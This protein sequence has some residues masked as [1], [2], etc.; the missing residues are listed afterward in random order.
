MV[1]AL[2]LSASYLAANTNKT[3]LSGRPLGQNL[4]METVGFNELLASNT[5]D[6][7]GAD[8]QTTYFYS[9]STNPEALG[10]YFGFND[11]NEFTAYTSTSADIN[12]GGIIYDHGSSRSTTEFIKLEPTQTVYGTRL[13]YQQN[14][15]SIFE[16]LWFRVKLPIVKVSNDMHMST[17]GA[18][19]AI[20]TDISNY[21]KGE[22]QA[23]NANDTS[24]EARTPLANALINGKRTA[25]NFAD[26][27]ANLGYTAIDNDRYTVDVNIGL[28]LPTGTKTTGMY[29]WEP[30]TGNN[31]HYELGAGVSSV[32]KLWS[33]DKGTVNFNTALDYRYGFKAT[34]KRTF[35]LNGANW[36]QYQLA[37]NVAV[38]ANN[39]TIV[40][41]PAANFLTLKAYVTPGSMLDGL[42][43]ITY[44]RGDMALDLGYNFFYKEK[45][46]VTL[47]DAIT[48]GTWRQLTNLAL[49]LHT[50]AN[51]ASGNV[52]EIPQSR[53]NTLSGSAA[54]TSHTLYANASY[55]F[56]KMHY[57][58]MIGAG[59]HYE[60]TG[61][62]SAVE[63]WG[64]NAKTGFSF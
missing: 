53:I 12:L 31:G 1:A 50:S 57:P 30:V 49:N 44:N 34:E 20:S 42:A 43:G 52:T 23:L 3:F 16:G 15:D 28:T 25:S 5:F 26:V 18:N 11:K 32:V 61:T 46:S 2:S 29:A 38:G 63:N 62:N 13:Q 45:S 59:V 6:S 21:F 36:G 54:A 14:L 8:L 64:I 39:Q 51:L 48:D 55:M 60:F 10:K 35:G 40:T 27:S 19:S 24:G 56:S 22:L 17:R 33:N 9:R 58:M 47:R 7:F 4:A 41:T 37:T